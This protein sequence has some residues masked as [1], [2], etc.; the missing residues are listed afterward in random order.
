[1]L[2]GKLPNRNTNLIRKYIT[3]QKNWDGLRTKWKNKIKGKKHYKQ[4]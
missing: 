2:E 4:K 1:M 3:V